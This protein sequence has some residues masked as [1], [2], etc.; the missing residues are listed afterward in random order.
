MITAMTSR[1]FEDVPPSLGLWKI[2]KIDPQ[3]TIIQGQ[4][5]M[6]L[7]VNLTSDEQLGLSK[8]V[9]IRWSKRDFY[10]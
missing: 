2:W 1:I 9:K 7:V 10:I 6:D 5:I 8:H 4:I 3:K